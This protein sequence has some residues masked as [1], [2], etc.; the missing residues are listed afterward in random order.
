MQVKSVKP[1]NAIGIISAKSGEML[2]IES[3]ITAI[4]LEQMGFVEKT[5]DKEPR[6][7]TKKTK[8]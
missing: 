6:A 3:P 2:E 1:F 4:Q 8:K 7:E 5:S